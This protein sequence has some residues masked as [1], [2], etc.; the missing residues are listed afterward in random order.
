MAYIKTFFLLSFMTAIFMFIGFMIGGIQGMLIAFAIALCMN[1]FSYWNSDKIVLKMYK[2]KPVDPF[3][4]PQIVNMIEELARHAQI[5]TPK[6]YMM[7]N[8]QPNAFATGRNPE[9]AAVAMT[10]GIMKLLTHD[11]LK[12]VIAHEMAHIKNRDTLTMTMTATIAGAIGMVAT[13]AR[14]MGGGIRRGRS[15][16]GGVAGNAIMI[17][18]VAIIAPIAATIVKLAISRTREYQA[19]RVG[20]Q[21]CADPLSLAHALEKIS[22][23]A[24]KVANAEAQAHPESAHLFIMNPLAGGRINSL[25]STHPNTQSRIDKLVELSKTMDYKKSLY[26]RSSEIRKSRIIKKGTFD[27]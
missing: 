3:K 17:L 6:A 26:T 19:D 20:A 1:M 27:I 13:W 5:P 14:Y 12:G 25:F 10:T 8:D 15:A 2:A 9:N 18:A 4:Y 22:N 24:A 7:E 21:I 11:E 23:G 16:N